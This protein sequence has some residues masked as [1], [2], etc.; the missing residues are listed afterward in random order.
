MEIEPLLLSNRKCTRPRK[1]AVYEV[2]CALL[3]LLKSGC[4]WDM[5][6]S[7]FPPKSTV[8]YYFKLWKEKPSETDLSLL[9]QALKKCRWR[10]PYQPWSKRQHHF[11]DS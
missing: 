6:P 11:L 8:Y 7:D 5:L 1:V 4:Q 2:F 9:E 3:Y 10:G